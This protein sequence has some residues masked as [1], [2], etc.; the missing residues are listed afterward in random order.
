MNWPGHNIYGCYKD[1]LLVGFTD[2]WVLPDFF[3]GGN[4]LNIQNLYVIPDLRGHG[5]GTALMDKIIEIA[6]KEKVTDIHVEVLE[7]NVEAQEFYT[8]LGLNE[9]MCLL[10]GQFTD[11]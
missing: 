11:D 6:K 5:I 7:E 3:H 8:K 2:F 10:Q 9:K 1:G 4:I